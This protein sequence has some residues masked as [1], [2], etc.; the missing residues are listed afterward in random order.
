MLEHRTSRSGRWLRANRARLALA[1]A[2]VE[3]ILVATD[4]ISWPVALV[5]ALAA[6]AVYFTVGRNLVSDTLRQTSWIAAMS[7]VLV[8][9]V[10][11]LLFVVGAV[12]LFLLGIAAL[13]A[14]VALL[15]DRR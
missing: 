6:F 8:A 15:A 7:Q 11:V 4:A 14:L 10:P 1:I 2:V 5:L 12:A 13:V 9:L 3:G